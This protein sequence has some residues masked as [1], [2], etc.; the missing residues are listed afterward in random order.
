[1]QGILWVLW[2]TAWIYA[3]FEAMG[4]VGDFIEPAREKLS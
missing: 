4:I 2:Q 3:H 1:L